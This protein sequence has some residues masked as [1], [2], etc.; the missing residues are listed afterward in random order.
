[1]VVFIIVAYDIRTD[2]KAGQRRLRKVAKICQRIGQ[3]VQKSVFE[4]QIDEVQYVQLVHQL[5]HVM[6]HADDNI[7][8]YR[9]PSQ[10]NDMIL[11]LGHGRAID[12]SQPLIL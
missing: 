10:P 4:F 8:L 1:M 12:Y 5:R 3:R 6:H 2:T 7:R 11:Q 9:L